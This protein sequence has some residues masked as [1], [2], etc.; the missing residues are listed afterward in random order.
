MVFPVNNML[1]LLFVTFSFVFQLGRNWHIILVMPLGTYWAWKYLPICKAVWKGEKGWELHY[2]TTYWRLQAIGLSPTSALAAKLVKFPYQFLH[3]I[4]LLT[5]QRLNCSSTVSYLASPSL[6]PLNILWV[7]T[8]P[9]FGLMCW[10]YFQ[11][12]LWRQLLFGK[13]SCT[14]LI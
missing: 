12:F 13:S 1:L 6:R 7:F 14:C 4:H 11:C 5:N 2:W 9:H 3:S 8:I 10:V